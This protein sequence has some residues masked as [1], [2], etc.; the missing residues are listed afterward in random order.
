[1]LPH[2]RRPYTYVTARS[3][4]LYIVTL[5]LSGALEFSFSPEKNPASFKHPLRL[6]IAIRLQARCADLQKIKARFRQ[7]REGH[8]G[9]F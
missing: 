5:E 1:M 3:A 9:R 4:S 6:P 2:V 8:N 7:S